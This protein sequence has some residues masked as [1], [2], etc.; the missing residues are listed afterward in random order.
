[1]YGKRRGFGFIGGAKLV[2]LLLVAGVMAGGS[3]AFTASNTVSA[4]PAGEGESAAISGYTATNA[5]WTLDTSDPTRIAKVEFDLSPVTSATTVYAG[6][7]NGTTVTWSG[8]CSSSGGSGHEHDSSGSG[9]GS[10]HFTCSFSSEPSV[11]DT[12][13][14]AVSAA[15]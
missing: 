5:K 4:A 14:L 15:N 3:Y 10:G 7:D 9:S 1:M 8:L 2:P 6:A 12:T 11:S 13:K